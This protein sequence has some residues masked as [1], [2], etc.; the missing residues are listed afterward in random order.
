MWT[1]AAMIGAAAVSA[2]GQYGMS[3]G[4]SH[5][6]HKY[7]N[8]AA[9]TAFQRQLYIMQNAHQMEMSDLKKA[10]LNPALTATGGS[11]A[12]GSAPMASSTTGHT[13]DKID[14]LSANAMQ[15]QIKNLK[16]QQAKTL[17]ETYKASE[18]AQ[19]VQIEN[20]SSALSLHKQEKE[21]QAFNDWFESLDTKQKR[22][23]ISRVDGQSG[24]ISREISGVRDL[25]KNQVSETKTD[26]VFKKGKEKQ[27]AFFQ[28]IQ[29]HDLK[30]RYNPDPKKVR[31]KFELANPD[32]ADHGVRRDIDIKYKKPSKKGKK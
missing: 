28:W 32:Q 4:S 12:S 19:K 20:K 14:L 8:R 30:K 10:G 22:D 16:A 27:N 23:W 17:V 9:E 13:F 24:H 3:S 11:G 18:E 6:E 15:E 31:A 26:G 7:Q 1:T 5:R 29:S 21:L 25:I 2:L